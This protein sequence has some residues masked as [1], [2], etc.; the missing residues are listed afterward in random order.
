MSKFL[1]QISVLPGDVHNMMIQ[2][3]KNHMY[4]W[5]LNNLV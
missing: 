1:I 5:Y 3:A 2:S 4:S